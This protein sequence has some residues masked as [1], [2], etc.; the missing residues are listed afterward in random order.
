MD[1]ILLGEGLSALLTERNPKQFL[2]IIAALLTQR[3]LDE[4]TLLC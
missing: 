1:R 2:D 4:N 3:I